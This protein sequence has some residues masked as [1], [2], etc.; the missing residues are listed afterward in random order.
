MLFESHVVS[1]LALVVGQL[2]GFVV[3][4]WSVQVCI[5][6]GILGTRVGGKGPAPMNTWKTLGVDR[7]R[8]R[9]DLVVSSICRSILIGQRISH[10]ICFGLVSMVY[11]L[12]D[13]GHAQCFP[14]T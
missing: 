8:T 1:T 14:Q 13:P 11:L 4:C 6:D 12:Q 5:F 3:M 2:E 9:V 7:D 10:G